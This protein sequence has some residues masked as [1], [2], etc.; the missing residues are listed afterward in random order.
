MLYTNGGSN[1]VFIPVLNIS[2]KSTSVSFT[3]LNALPLAVIWT[4][5][6]RIK[7]R[8]KNPVKYLRWVFFAKLVSSLYS[9]VTSAKNIHH[10]W[11]SNYAPEIRYIL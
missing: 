7:R 4:L 10:R 8:I 1:L 6:V 11:I 5:Q 3:C 2:V 9:V